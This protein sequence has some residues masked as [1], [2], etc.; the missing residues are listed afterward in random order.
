M[1]A[2]YSAQQIKAAVAA[3]NTHREKQYISHQWGELV[4]R[5]SRDEDPQL[6]EKMFRELDVLLENDS[7]FKIFSKI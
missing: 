1:V 5:L 7:G 2:K 3:L 4:L 6:R